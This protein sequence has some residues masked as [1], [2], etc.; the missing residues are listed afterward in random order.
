MFLFLFIY[1]WIAIFLLLLGDPVIIVLYGYF[2]IYML[3]YRGFRLAIEIILDYGKSS[4]LQNYLKS[5]NK[6][7]FNRCGISWTVC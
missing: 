2:I 5:I 7:Y 1:I 6:K 3:W 4:P